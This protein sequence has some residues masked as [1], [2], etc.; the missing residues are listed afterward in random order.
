[1]KRRNFIQ[2]LALLSF[3]ALAPM[4]SF[5]VSLFQSSA[6]AIQQALQALVQIM[7]A[8]KAEG[9]DVV[10]KTLNGKRYKRDAG[11]HYPYEDSIEDKDTSCQV[12]FHAHRKNEY[13]HFHTFINNEQGEL[14]HL[15]MISMDKHGQPTA[16]STLNRWVTGDV[17]VKAEEIK[18]LFQKFKMN[19]A[20][21]PDKR[22]I[23]FVENIFV[24]YQP[25]IF[26]LFEE[27][28]NRITQ[29]VEL[30]ASEPFEDRG[31]EILSSRKINVY[32]P[33]AATALR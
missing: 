15:V 6:V 32:A 3:G 10:K 1:M 5:S 18:L 2:T 14:V 27:R 23:E 16:I 19:H 31:V 28:D 4:R 29:Y 12:F 11:V 20:L 22:I 21:F 24:A 33:D 26:E 25:L 13:G 8:L 30:N 17:F 9:S 7:E